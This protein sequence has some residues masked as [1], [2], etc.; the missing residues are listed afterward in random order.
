VETGVIVQHHRSPSNGSAYELTA[1]GKGLL[2]VVEKLKLWLGESPNAERP[3]GGEGAR[4][5]IKAITEGWSAGLLRALAAKPLS[6]AEL[7]SLIANL[8]YPSLERRMTAMRLVGQVEAASANGRETPYTVTPWLR[9]G[10]GLL[11]AATRWERQY[12]AA[13]SMPITAMD[14]EAAFLLAAP[15]LRPETD[16]SG[17]CR[18]AVELPKRSE[19]RLAGALIMLEGGS[20]ASCSSRLD[21]SA[22]AWASGPLSAWLRAVIDGDSASL[23]LGGD[24]RLARS[25]VAGLHRALFLKDLGEAP[26]QR[27]RDLV[28]NRSLG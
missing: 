3:L 18:L 20:L 13:G 6:V 14:V 9:R 23:E 19:Q 25:V 7:D 12:L 27:G 1:A 16:L 4:A 10:V 24:G 17:R 26:R 11:L 22:D 5:A 8:N 15:L 28:A 21:R 2:A